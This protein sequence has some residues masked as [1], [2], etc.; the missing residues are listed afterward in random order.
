[1]EQDFNSKYHSELRILDLIDKY[2]MLEEIVEK[3]LKKAISYDERS[4]IHVSH[5]IKTMKSI[6]GKLRDRHNEFPDVN[7]LYDLLGFRVICYFQEDIDEIAELIAGSFRI[8][9]SRSKDRREHADP[10]SFGYT[11]LHYI[12]ALPEDAECPDVLRHLWFEVQ[13]RT[14]LMHSWAEIEHDLGYKT[15]FGVPRAIRRKFSQVSG[16]LETA[17][18]MF[19]DIRKEMADYKALVRENIKNDCADDMELDG[20]TLAEFTSSSKIYQSLLNDIAANTNAHIT[21]A[22]PENQLKLLDF[23]GIHTLGD[24]VEMI[25][26]NRDLTLELAHKRLSGSDLEELTT[27]APFYYLYRARLI[28]SDFSYEKIKEFL[29]LTINDPG[30]VRWT[31]NWIESERFALESKQK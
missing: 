10:T 9:W 7:S 28:Q 31:A 24:L 6:K 16:L 30:T 21:Y 27:T 19:S 26:K 8:D 17:D 13:I 4:L 25:R 20:V 2:K 14:I 12:C 5:R 18:N 23:L 29:S 11:S 3:R 15:E 1:M 22:N